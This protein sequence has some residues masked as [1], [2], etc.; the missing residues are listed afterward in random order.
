[1]AYIKKIN[2]NTKDS[3]Q[4]SPGYVLTFTRFSNRD[5]YN[6]KEVDNLETRKP[7]VVV[8]DAIAI[9][10][11]ESKSN[12]TPTLSCILKQG[13]LNYLT[14]IHP[15]DF[16]TV[17]MVNWESDA[18]DIRKRAIDG[19]AIN[20][21]TDGFKGLF[22]ILD[23][24][25]A[26]SV[27]SNGEKE[28]QVQVTA[29]G[30]DEFNNILY[31]NPALVNEVS[32]TGGGILF[33]N[34][35]S[36]FKDL[37][38][39]KESSNVQALVKA[40]IDRT[41][42]PGLSVESKSKLNQISA[43]EVP[44][45]V[46]SLLNIEKAKYISDIN[47]YYLGIWRNNGSTTVIEKNENSYEG[48]Y[49]FFQNYAKDNK[50]NFYKSGSQLEGSRQ[51]SFQDFQSVSV[52]SLMQDYSNPILNE[53]YTC[54]RIAPDGHVYPSLV[55]RQKPFNTMHYETKGPSQDHTKFLNLPRWKIDSDLITSLNIGR[56]DQGRINFVQV[57]S[58][59]LSVDANFDAAAQIT[60]G[61][62]VEDTKDV[63]R[64]GRKPY[65]ITCNYDPPNP[66]TPGLKARQWA[67]LMSDWLFD[68]HLKMNG[69]IESVGIQQ[70]ICIGDNIE[71]DNVVYHIETINHTMSITNNGSKIFR[72]RLSLSMGVDASSN[73]NI[74]VYA[75]MAHTDSFTRRQDDYKKEK[76]L[77]G[78]SD[79]QDIPGRELGEEIEETSEASFTNP[80]SL[81]KGNKK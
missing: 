72:T 46:G 57:F 55:V 56:S 2:K 33:L 12:P 26:L 18:M 20:R 79:T 37:V 40:V 19:Q 35:F 11:E 17:N 39:T 10:I 14:A 47:K 41:I 3:H 36:N 52:W 31:F 66:S 42:G 38:Q 58:R 13:D 59:S 25:M 80:N 53:S 44:I 43:Y 60:L 73:K 28:Y 16:V 75:E 8:N 9:S 71:L 51:V 1:M 4:T 61:N 74:P 15:G 68:G 64:H 65:I 21:A 54:Y 23:V 29:R 27:S 67:Y 6:Y 49:N 76:L 5:T 63:K 77:P 32:N 50:S 69:T 7:L 45:Q 81:N 22:K 48:F 78:F 24:N 34:A 30:F 70:P 62:F